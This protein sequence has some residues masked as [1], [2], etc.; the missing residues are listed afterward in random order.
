MN[1][2]RSTW[3]ERADHRAR[4]YDARKRREHGWPCC[5]RLTTANAAQRVER[6]LLRHLTEEEYRALD[7]SIFQA[8]ILATRAAALRWASH[9][10]KL[11]PAD[12]GY[13]RRRLQ[14][15]RLEAA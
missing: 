9:K 7:G 14:L 3:S 6:R 13:G 4:S 11:A 10:F 12:D 5:F 1:R 8:D 15:V 2:K